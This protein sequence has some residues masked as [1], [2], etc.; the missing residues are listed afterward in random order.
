MLPADSPI[1]VAGFYSKA[2]LLVWDYQG[3][4]HDSCQVV[5]FWDEGETGSWAAPNTNLCNSPAATYQDSDKFGDAKDYPLMC[6]AATEKNS[7]SDATSGNTRYIIE[8]SYTRSG[9]TVPEGYVFFTY[10]EGDEPDSPWL[11]SPAPLPN[12]G[13]ALIK[14]LA[15]SAGMA[16]V[17]DGDP[18]PTF[19]MPKFYEAFE[20]IE[21]I[22]FPLIFGG[23]DGKFDDTDIKAVEAVLSTKICTGC[24]TAMFDYMFLSWNE[25][26]DDG[27]CVAF[28][29]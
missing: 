10:R 11:T 22:L 5:L 3:S 28:I 1:L 21:T 27:V 25:A 19:C 9:N 4:I 29:H 16:C 23:A 13:N 14:M 18:T 24:T 7:Q 2:D 6:S 17:N 20:S 26:T 12:S 8:S 15:E